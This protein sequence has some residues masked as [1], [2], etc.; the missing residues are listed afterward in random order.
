MR[1]RLDPTTRRSRSHAVFLGRPAHE[2][3][4]YQPSSERAEHSRS[5]GALCS[6]MERRMS[7]KTIQSSTSALIEFSPS[8]VNASATTELHDEPLAV[9][10]DEL[11]VSSSSE[12]EL[13]TGAT[14]DTPRM[15]SADTTASEAEASEPCAQLDAIPPTAASGEDSLGA[16]LARL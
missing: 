10:G 11:G 6:R 16:Q 14:D 15:V 13:L 1:H 8:S 2:Q 9:S 5:G 3:P 12:F 7:S 4:K